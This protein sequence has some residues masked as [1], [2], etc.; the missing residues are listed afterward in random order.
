MTYVSLLFFPPRHLRR[1]TVILAFH[2]GSPERNLCKR[3]KSG[4]SRGGLAH[5]SYCKNVNSSF[6]IKRLENA[7]LLV[8]LPPFPDGTQQCALCAEK[9]ATQMTLS[10]EAEVLRRASHS[11]ARPERSQSTEV[12]LSIALTYLS[13]RERRVT[14]R[15]PDTGEGVFVCVSKNPSSSWNCSSTLKG[16]AAQVVLREPRF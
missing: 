1:I 4:R 6:H 14:Q 3:V 10:P 8:L 2:D 9:N 15:Q 11:N 5:S 13:E 12:G 16:N 7:A